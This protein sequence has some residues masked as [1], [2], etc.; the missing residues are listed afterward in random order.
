MAESTERVKSMNLNKNV[1]KELE[2]TPSLPRQFGRLILLKK[3]ARGGMGEVYLAAAGGIEGAERACV[4]K[5]IRREHQDDRSFR[6]RFLDETRIQA[7][8][9]HPGV[10]QIIDSATDEEDCP[11]AVVEYVEGRHLG[12]IVA[13]SNQLGMSIS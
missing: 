8:L 7:Q 12:E 2:A 1:E 13:H 5:K 3:V 9:Q 11:Y 6:A 10:A 4:V